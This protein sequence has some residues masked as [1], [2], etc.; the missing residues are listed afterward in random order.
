MIQFKTV[1]IIFIFFASSMTA[2]ADPNN[3][4]EINTLKF[5]VRIT[6]DEKNIVLIFDDNI[7]KKQHS[8]IDIMRIN[9]L[10]YKTRLM[11]YFG[12]LLKTKTYHFEKLIIIDGNKTLELEFNRENISMVINQVCKYAEN[13][14]P[15]QANVST[16]ALQH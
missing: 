9:D 14:V 4:F 8:I 15:I 2:I 1:L 10:E 12:G 13:L 3:L 7:S 11:R 6:E 5:G 16:P